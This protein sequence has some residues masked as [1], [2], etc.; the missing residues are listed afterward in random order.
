MKNKTIPVVLLWVAVL[1]I[2]KFL[3]K[4]VLAKMRDIVAEK[5][6]KAKYA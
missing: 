2:L 3:L 1:I 4:L 5:R 6:I